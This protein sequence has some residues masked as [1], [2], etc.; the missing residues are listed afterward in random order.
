MVRPQTRIAK[1]PKASGWYCGSRQGSW[2]CACSFSPCAG[3]WCVCLLETRGSCRSRFKSAGH[4]QQYCRPT[5][6]LQLWAM[7]L[8]Q[9][10]RLP[11]SSWAAC[12]R[13][14]GYRRNFCPRRRF[15]SCTTSFPP[16]RPLRASRPACT[17]A[18]S[19]SLGPSRTRVLRS[20]TSTRSSLSSVS[21]PA[22][23]SMSGLPRWWRGWNRR[24]RTPC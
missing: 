14:Q 12:S 16:L 22:M 4:K 10:S 1:R 21:A 13:S 2:G 5:K 7:I 23:T 6:H 15:G 3:A 17:A 18:R 11:R 19:S 24:G 8:H 9:P 20:P